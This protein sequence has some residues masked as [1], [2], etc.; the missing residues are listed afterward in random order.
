MK[1]KISV[2]IN[3]KITGYN[4]TIK[5]ASDKSL[6]LRALILASQCIGV[7]KIKNLLESEDVA[8]CIKALKKLGVKIVK[9]NNIHFI[10]GNGLN[11]F[12][13][14]KKLIK[15]YVGNSGTT[16]RLLSGL[17]STQNNKFYLYG[18]KSMNRR[19]MSRVI[20]P[21]EKVGCFFYPK[22]KTTLPFIIEGT[23]MPLAQ[24]HIEKKGSAQIKSLI[25]LSALSTPGIT[26]VEEKKASRNHTEI[27]LKEIGA[28]IKVKKI[29]KNNLITLSGQKNLYSFNYTIYSDPSSA[30]FLIALTLL[31]PNSKLIIKNVICN[32]TRIGFFKILKEKM[33][34]N[35]RIKNLRKI[36]GEPIGDIIIKSSILKPINCPKELVPFL[37]DEF[38]ILFVIA[39]LTKGLSKF[40][41]INELR[42]K[43]SDRIENMEKG[44]NKIGIKTKST[45]DSLEIY[46]NPNIKIKKE[47][48]I[49]S[50]EDHRIAM[51][52]A[53]LGLLIDGKLK[54]HNFETVNTSFPGFIKLI[55]NIGG[56]IEIK[57]N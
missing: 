9:K 8:N 29:K 37:I 4:K 27:F 22:K 56:K 55:K 47:L 51:S 26:T 52:W 43:E 44:F 42:H 16:A 2:L 11:S 49:F 10:Y 32:P 19:D 54:I 40:T 31:T 20:E 34:A 21:L 14:N 15:I 12:K 45:K 41:G 36:S 6:S 28:N 1:K 3:K 57:K 23:S 39:A 33:N 13:A 50:K 17:F 38:C 24:K 46:G 30:S 35:I 18:D 25:L 53:I 7:S 5:V 48:N